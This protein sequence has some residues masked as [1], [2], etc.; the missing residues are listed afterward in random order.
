MAVRGWQLTKTSGNS[1]K[2]NVPLTC[3]KK[4]NVSNKAVHSLMA[5]KDT[6][7]KNE[8]LA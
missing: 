1:K 3:H 5:A 4:N 6:D 8:Y 2:R 7:L